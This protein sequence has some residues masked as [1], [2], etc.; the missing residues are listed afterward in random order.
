MARRFLAVVDDLTA[1]RGD[2]SVHFLAPPPMHLEAE[3]PPARR[4]GDALGDA[5]EQGALPI[6]RDNGGKPED[7]DACR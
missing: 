5:A 6:S 7:K 1:R 3:Q 4:V 2:E